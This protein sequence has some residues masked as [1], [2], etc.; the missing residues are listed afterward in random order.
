MGMGHYE[1]LLIQTL[2]QETLGSDEWRFDITFEGRPTPQP[3]DAESLDAALD[4][5]DFLGYSTA[6]LAKVPLAAATTLLNLRFGARPDVYHSL[7]LSFP[8]PTNA[9]GV[10]TI[11]DLPPARFPDEGTLAPWHKR[12]AQAAQ[13]VMTPS[14]FA[15]GELIELLDL[16]PEKVVVI[17]YGC[18]HDRYHPT[19]PPADISQLKEWGI[20]GDFVLYAGGFTRRKNVAALLQA[21]KQLAPRFPELTL[22]LAG[23]QAKLAELARAANAPRVYAMGYVAH[24]DMPSLMKAAR[25]LV[26][27]SIY[28]GFGLPPQEAMALGVPVVVSKAGGAVPEVVGDAGVLAED[29]SAESL[30]DALGKLL[31]DAALQEQLKEAGPQRAQLFSWPEHARRVL[32]VYRRAIG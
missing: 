10:F 30:G 1:R 14:E 12:A 11:H 27:P 29:G 24:L 26:F 3:I 13:F 8:L 23:P 9:P 32:E 28:E 22:V 2:G 20:E 7:A 15:R 5:A 18:E 17:P 25:A 19:V 16:A 4:K 6:R 31:G 21:W